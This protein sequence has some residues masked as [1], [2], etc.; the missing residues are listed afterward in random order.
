MP[1]ITRIEHEKR[2]RMVQEWII[3]DW[4]SC[5]IVIQSVAKWG[6]SDRQAKRYIAD[7]IETWK[8]G[9]QEKLDS[10]RS[11]RIES[12]KKLKRSLKPEFKG[13]PAGIRTVLMIER[14]LIKLQGVTPT[15]Q[16]IEAEAAVMK[17]KQADPLAPSTNVLKI[18][19][20]P[21]YGHDVK[22]I[23]TTG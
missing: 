17:G 6:V 23:G 9:N 7:A 19:L 2:L 11:N 4:P 12:L 20:L 13:T 22:T 21:A 10:K 1:K 15:E 14:E 3:D 18:E 5:D 8:A 16:M